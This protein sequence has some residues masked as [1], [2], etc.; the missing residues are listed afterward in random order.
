MGH[1]RNRPIPSADKLLGESQALYDAFN[2][3]EDLPCVL[4][5]TSYLDA[6]LEAMLHKYFI[7]SSVANAILDPQTGFLGS[8]SSRAK[9]AYCLGLISKPMYINL[10]LIGQLRNRFA[11]EYLEVTFDDVKAVELTNQFVMPTFGGG[12]RVNADGTA[13][14]LTARPDHLDTPRFRLIEIAAVIGAQ[15]PFETQQLA[16]SSTLK[17]REAKAN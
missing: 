15:L 7:D 14:Q 13:T 6:C 10:D 4:L 16:K 11:H 9:L 2:K 3:H 12:V 1:K 5:V 8:L 17:D